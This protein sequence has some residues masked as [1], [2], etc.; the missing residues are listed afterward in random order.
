MTAPTP[1]APPSLT[2]E[3]TWSAPLDGFAITNLAPLGDV[4]L[5]AGRVGDRPEL[6]AARFTGGLVRVDPLPPLPP[7]TPKLPVSSGGWYGFG[8][9][10]PWVFVDDAPGASQFA[11][12]LQ[13]YQGGCWGVLVFPGLGAPS[14][15]EI[16]TPV[17]ESDIRFGVPLALRGDEIVSTDGSR[18]YHLR[19]HA[20]SWASHV[21]AETQDKEEIGWH[22]G[23]S[24]DGKTLVLGTVT[25]FSADPEDLVFFERAPDGSFAR[26]RRLRIAD[27]P[28]NQITGL[29]FDGDELVVGSILRGPDGA[30]LFVLPP[31]Y[32]RPAQRIAVPPE[33]N[34]TAVHALAASGGLAIVAQLE[35]IWGADLRAAEVTCGLKLPPL[36]QGARRRIH[37][38]AFW[39]DRGVVAADGRIGVFDMGACR[40]KGP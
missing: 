22:S 11:V 16:A 23:L 40:A 33:T 9:V 19:R 5:V 14:H 15:E 2:I 8:E 21:D 27:A 39:G 29:T 31:P 28:R 34:D 25:Q 38:V 4:L 10:T 24:P 18:L 32:D 1:P 20:A 36:A 37:A 13:E 35:S 17:D 7:P 6:R 30:S 12:T 3:G 26:R